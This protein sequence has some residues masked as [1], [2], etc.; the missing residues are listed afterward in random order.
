MKNLC[1]LLVAF[2]TTVS[3]GQTKEYASLEKNTNHYAKDLYHN[4]NKTKDTLILKSDKPLRYIYSINQEYNREIDTYAG[5][6]DFN[7]PLDS[8]TLGKHVFVVTQSSK[9]IIFVVHIYGRNQ[10][11]ASVKTE[12]DITVATN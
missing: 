8:L 5:K 6:N 3:V 4:L 7:I 10:K 1:F 2:I 11:M 12:Q 9:R